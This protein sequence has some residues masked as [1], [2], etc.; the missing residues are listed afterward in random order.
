MPSGIH[1][2]R[3]IKAWFSHAAVVAATE[4]PVLPEKLM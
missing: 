4:L 2:F 1:V 3:Y